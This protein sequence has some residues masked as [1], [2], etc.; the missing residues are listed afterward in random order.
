[1]KESSKLSKAIEKTRAGSLSGLEELYLLSYKDTYEDIRFSVEDEEYIW[2]IIRDVY[3]QVYE[4]HEGMPEE[5][6]LRQWIRIL[7]KEVAGKK[8]GVSIEHFP[9]ITGEDSS[10]VEA[11]EPKA[12][13]TLIAIEEQL[14]LLDKDYEDAENPKK[15]THISLK[16]I[17]ALILV[18]IAIAMAVYVMIT[19]KDDATLPAI[20]TALTFTNII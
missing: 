9:E 4:R 6:L 19:M 14:G 3:I 17:G 10:K 12:N 11:I 18:L 8:E 20:G 5:S 7:I 13:T 16:M 15:A 2:N 1:M